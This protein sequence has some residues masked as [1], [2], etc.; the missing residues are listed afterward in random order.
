MKLALQ[1]CCTTPIFLKHYETS[2]NAVLGRLG[3]QLTDKALNCCGYPLKN[4]NYKA[5]VLASARNLSIAEKRKVDIMTFCNC[6]Y[7]TLKEVDQQLKADPALNAEMN[8][9]LEKEALKY[10][11]G[12]RIQHIMEVFYHDLGPERIRKNIVK[13][14]KGVKIAV[15]YGCH[16]LRPRE[17]VQFKGPGTT[18]V[19]DELVAMTGADLVPW[20]LQT[21]CCGSPMWGID[22]KLSAALTRKKIENARASGAHYFCLACSYCQV[23]L[24]RVQ[25]RLLDEGLIADPM[26]SILFTQLLGLSMGIDP[27]ILGIEENQIDISPILECLD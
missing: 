9:K 8:G 1:R 18:K 24:D 10:E 19:F 22:D 25:K 15:H 2:T 14:F 17:L 12:V 27:H 5:Y 13:K 20:Q 6:C 23:Q 16:I 3:V 11:G 26:P 4:Y 7:G 21:E